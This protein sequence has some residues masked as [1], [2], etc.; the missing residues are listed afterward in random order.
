MR[1][2]FVFLLFYII[3]FDK[4]QVGYRP[5]RTED[6]LEDNDPEEKWILEENVKIDNAQDL[7]PEELAEKEELSL[8]GFTNWTKKDFVSFCKANEKYGRE[9]LES[10]TS[11]IGGKTL[12]EVKAYA[13]VF[14]NRYKEITGFLIFYFL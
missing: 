2:G 11:D 1:F 3:K 8:E 5:G 6:V 14:W 7:T 13:A 4:K 9:D 12:E 10:I